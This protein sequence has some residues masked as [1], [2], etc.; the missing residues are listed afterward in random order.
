M[1]LIIGSFFK[2]NTANTSAPQLLVFKCFKNMWSGLD[3]ITFEP[4]I[5]QEI[6]YMV[7]DAKYEILSCC[8]QFSNPSATLNRLP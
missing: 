7:D 3:Q 2:A 1:K 8:K 4:R 5:K 6:P